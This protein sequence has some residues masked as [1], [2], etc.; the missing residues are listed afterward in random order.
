MTRAAR[1]VCQHRPLYPTQAGVAAPKLRETALPGLD[2]RVLAPNR[3][4]LPPSP[5]PPAPAAR[6]PAPGAGMRSR[7]ARTYPSAGPG[8]RR[9]CRRDPPGARR[10][11]G[12]C[13]ASGAQQKTGLNSGS[14][15][16][17]TRVR[18]AARPPRRRAPAGAG[19][20]Q[21]GRG[22]GDTHAGTTHGDGQAGE[23]GRGAHPEE[24]RVLQP[25]GVEV[26]PLLAQPPAEVVQGDAARCSPAA[27]SLHQPFS[28]SGQASASQAR[29]GGP[30]RCPGRRCFAAP[31]LRPTLPAVPA[32]RRSPSRARPPAPGGAHGSPARCRHGAPRSPTERARA[33]GPVCARTAAP[34]ARLLRARTP[35][36]GTRIPA[37]VH[38]PPRPGCTPLRAPH[39][40]TCTI[41]PVYTHTRRT[42]YPPGARSPADA[43]PLCTHTAASG[44]HLRRAQAP[45]PGGARRLRA[46]SRGITPAPGDAHSPR[47]SP[48]L[49]PVPP[50]AYTRCGLRG[51]LRGWGERGAAAG[52]A[53]PH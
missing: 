40:P 2:S 23:G 33:L 47:P 21:P 41:P 20:G 22:A 9:R 12:C 38:S 13:P 11:P 19:P 49:P 14:A 46:A 31:A 28:R 4:E 25:H 24:Q 37:S 30:P 7:R 18:G 44:A 17:E 15:G 5:A 51:G 1:R 42:Q 8:R 29:A 35:P 6:D 10:P 53:K 34:G 48:R 27:R 26:H 39:P 3:R 52:M 16:R 43:H 32:L 45:T 36:P 50:S